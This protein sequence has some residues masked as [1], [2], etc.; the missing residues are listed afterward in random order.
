MYKVI[1][2]SII[3]PARVVFTGDRAAC[4][5]YVAAQLNCKYFPYGI[6]PLA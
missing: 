2:Y 3:G 4:A 5:A 1:A 6:Y